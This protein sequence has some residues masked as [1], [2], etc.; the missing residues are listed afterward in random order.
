MIKALSVT[1]YLFFVERHIRHKRN[2]DVGNV[3]AVGSGKNSHS[4]CKLSKTGIL[5]TKV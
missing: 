2:Y 5:F 3:G 4:A 1:S